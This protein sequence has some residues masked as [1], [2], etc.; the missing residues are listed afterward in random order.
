[1][2]AR[3]ARGVALE[4]LIRVASG[5]ASDRAL[6]RAL[7][8][9]GR[10]RLD[11]RERR[12]ATELVYGVLRR[13][14]SLDAMLEPLSKRPLGAL[15]VAVIEALRLGA[16][17]IRFLD[18]IPAHAAVAATVEAVK[19][20]AAPATGFVNA[21]LRNL[22]REGEGTV[23]GAFD[24]VPAWWADRWRRLYG[25]TDAAAWFAAALEPAP[26]AL[27]AH[28]RRIS[29]EALAARL[30]DEGVETTMSAVAP[31]A[32]R[33]LSGSPL[34][35][36][37]LREGGFSLR[38][39]AAQLVTGLLRPGPDDRV[40][41]A[42]AGRGGKTLQIAEDARPRSVIASD[43][44]PWRVAACRDAA[45]AAGLPTVMPLVAD[46]SVPAPFGACFGSVLVDVP[47]SGLGT[48]RRRPELKWRNDPA[49]LARLSRLQEQIL[50]NAADCMQPGGRL[51]YVT[52]S[53]EPEENEDVVQAVIERRG[54]LELQ[55]VELPEC[56]DPDLVDRH[57][58]FRTFPN[59]PELE[60]FFAASM[61]KTAGRP[62]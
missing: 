2:K 44:A 27:R 19:P 42:C 35:T 41:D 47:C 10:S 31:G 29:T 23:A 59:F 33:V 39:E 4:V 40:L 50:T 51:L 55:P 62:S 24:D 17:Q 20:H 48:V 8:I 53:T 36:D 5:A 11:D 14:R 34:A 30:A 49:R 52:C 38:G 7:R 54:D 61:V 45:R 37:V 56:T 28:P 57:G 18:R 60:G 26:L 15:D 16:Y 21:I 22:L 12:L 46:L 32:L 25:D 58:Y 9:G 1:M 3:E 6:D 13:R 43:V